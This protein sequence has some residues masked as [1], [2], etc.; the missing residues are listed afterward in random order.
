M[1]EESRVDP[2]PRYKRSPGKCV[3]PVVVGHSMGAALAGIY[4]ATYP[5]RGVVVVDQ[6][7]FV[8]PFAE[9]AHSL[10]LGVRGDDFGTAFEPIRQSIGIDRLPE[11]ERSRLA[12]RQRI[13]QDLVLGYW[14]EM[15]RTRSA[16][17]QARIDNTVPAIR[18]PFLAV[19]GHVLDAHEN[20]ALR[21][22]LPS[23]Q[24]EQWPDC[25]H[26]VHLAEPDRFACRLAA[27][28]SQCFAPGQP[29]RPAALSHEHD[30]LAACA[31]HG[32]STR[33]TRT[34]CASRPRRGGAGPHAGPGGPRRRVRADGPAGRLP[35]RCSRIRLPG[36]RP[37]GFALSYRATGCPHPGRRLLPQQP[38]PAHRGHIPA[39]P[40][41]AL[42]GPEA[43]VPAG[44]SSTENTPGELNLVPP[45][46][47][48]NALKFWLDMAAVKSSGPGHGTTILTNVGRT[49]SAVIAWL[50]HDRDFLIVS[51]PTPATIGQG[52][53]MASLVVG[54]SRSAN[55]GDPGCP[56]S[57]RCADLF[58]TSYWGSNSFSIG[59]DEEVRLYLGTIQ[60]SG[61]P[62]TFFTVLD[63]GDHADLLR[64]EQAAEPIIGS[65]RLPPSAAGG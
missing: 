27:F 29:G 17:F 13:R 41:N 55:Y 49:P 7:L 1:T 53:K 51:K 3:R 36:R 32:R 19:F 5:V 46:Q 38:L 54:V 11:P 48:D 39:R 22:F 21:R 26:L 23:A 25:G 44:W 61:R 30:D 31:R 28:A 34:D 14:D 24:V 45:G 6:T 15:L 4:A 2:G 10:A 60:V 20:Q 59:G 40:R 64:L 50:S 58:T 47:P 9:L 43:A 33:R 62:H 65:V 42:A 37:T 12:A 8:R 35:S 16:R 63:A 52:I 56:A 18:A 57:P